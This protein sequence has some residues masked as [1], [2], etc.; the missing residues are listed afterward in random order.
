MPCS[1]SSMPRHLDQIHVE[2]RRC[3][4]CQ[5]LAGFVGVRKLQCRSHRCSQKAIVV[6]QQY[7][8]GRRNTYNPQERRLE[9]TGDSG[10]LLPLPWVE[11]ILER[12]IFSLGGTRSELSASSES[13]PQEGGG[14]HRTKVGSRQCICEPPA[15]L[16]HELATSNR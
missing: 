11:H 1:T 7:I 2:S 6:R 5:F 15:G 12:T 9:N 16:L 8:A 14:Y 13:Q 4:I 3:T 10:L